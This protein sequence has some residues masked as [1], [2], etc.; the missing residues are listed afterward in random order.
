MAAADN[1]L[2][3]ALLPCVRNADGAD[4]LLDFGIVALTRRA[5]PA[6]IASRQSV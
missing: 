3:E 1:H 2:V 4:P 5:S 6:T